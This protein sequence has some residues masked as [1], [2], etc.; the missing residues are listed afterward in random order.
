MKK[1]ILGGGVHKEPK[2]GSDLPK[3]RGSWAL[4]RFNREPGGG[5]KRGCGV[6][7]GGGGGWCSNA[8]YVVVI[9]HKSFDNFIGV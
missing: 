2:I 9:V 6:L 4:W 5:Q 7:G 8:H 3:K 1:R